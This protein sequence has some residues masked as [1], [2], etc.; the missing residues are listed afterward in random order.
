MQLY[1]FNAHKHIVLPYI[2]DITASTKQMLPLSNTS[3]LPIIAF[4]QSVEPR[5]MEVGTQASKQQIPLFQQLPATLRTSRQ[6]TRAS[7]VTDESV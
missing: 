6:S 7:R 4:P 5:I 1:N 3:P 2:S